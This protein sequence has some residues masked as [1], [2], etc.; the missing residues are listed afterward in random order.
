MVSTPSV[1]TRVGTS[2][3]SVNCSNH[4][5]RFMPLARRRSAAWAR[6][7]SLGVGSYSWISAPTRVMDS[8]R[9]CSPATL[10][11][12]SART[13]KVV[14][15]TGRSSS[16]CVAGEVPHAASAARTIPST[17]VFKVRQSLKFATPNF[18]HYAGPPTMSGPVR[19]AGF[20]YAALVVCRD[21]ER[22]GDPR[23]DGPLF[24]PF[25]GVQTHDE[26]AAERLTFHKLDPHADAD[27]LAGQVAQQRRVGVVD[28]DDR[29]PASRVHVGQQAGLLC[30]NAAVAGRN[31]VA[32]R[33]DRGMAQ[34]FG[35]TFHKTV[36]DDVFEDLRLVVDLVPG[37]PEFLHEVELDQSVTAQYG[38]G[39]L[40]SRGGQSHVAVALVVDQPQFTEF[41]QHAGDRG[42]GHG[43]PLGDPG[44][45]DW[46]TSA[47]RKS[48]RL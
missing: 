19:C 28:T 14:S 25:V 37:V 24:N 26:R 36:R 7:R 35:D 5:S 46:A 34:A 38:Q 43:E 21:P 39:D 9:A 17:P 15:T 23:A 29:P 8:T 45:G 44:N 48:T 47:D 4:S 12:M 42:V 3:G 27:V 11:A 10:R 2:S 6:T 18:Y 41:A 16:S 22:F 40:V 30:R 1:T 32:V 20:D 31:G 13:V 33:V